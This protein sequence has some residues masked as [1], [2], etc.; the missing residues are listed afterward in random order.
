MSGVCNISTGRGLDDVRS[1]PS[2][3]NM[4]GEGRSKRTTILSLVYLSTSASL[5]VSTDPAR[6]ITV[7][8]ELSCLRPLPPNGFCEDLR[9]PPIAAFSLALGSTLVICL[10]PETVS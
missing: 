1:E 7:R 4:K 2:I 5:T 3:G 9:T 6:S 8:P 10:V